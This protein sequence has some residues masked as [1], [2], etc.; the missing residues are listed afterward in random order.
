MYAAACACR[1]GRGS[2]IKSGLRGIRQ[3]LELAPASSSL[4]A[5]KQAAL[6]LRLLP[7]HSSEA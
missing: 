2:N 6:S 3:K 4:L 5:L 1:A 7:R